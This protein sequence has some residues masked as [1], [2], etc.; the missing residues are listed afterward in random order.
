MVNDELADYN[1]KHGE[2]SIVMDSYELAGG[3]MHIDFTFATVSAYNDVNADTY[4]L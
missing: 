3:L 2:G 4:D 1:S